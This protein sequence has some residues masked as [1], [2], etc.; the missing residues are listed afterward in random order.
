[1]ILINC[2]KNLV[3]TVAYMIQNAWYNA[4]LKT[5]TNGF[6]MAK[7]K[8]SLEAIFC[9]IWLRVTIRKFKFIQSQL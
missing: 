2:H 6:A 4:S 7:V 9:G 3:Y 5:A 1:M 8:M